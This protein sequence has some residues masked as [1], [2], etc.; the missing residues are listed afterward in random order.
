[1]NDE[2]SA[3]LKLACDA[4]RLAGAHTLKYFQRENLKV[5]FKDDASPVTI[6][7]REAEQLIRKQVETAYPQD[8][9]IGEEF[10]DQSGTSGWRWIIDPIDGTKSFIHGVPLYSV[11]IGVGFNNES[12]IG[13]IHVPALSQTLYAAT[14]KGAWFRLG[15]QP[16]RP[17]R[18]SQTTTL[19][20]GTFLTSSIAGFQ[21]RSSWPA[22][23]RLT[24]AAKVTRTW[25]DAYGYLLVATGKAD[26]M[27]DPEMNIWDAAALLPIMQEAGGTYTDWR[28]RPAIDSGD[29]I[30]TNGLLLDEVL[31]LLNG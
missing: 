19:S 28:G 2:L 4:A 20:Q 21:K 1:M 25:G 5:D 6:A 14:G 10:G 17:A 22:F 23:E 13:V 31:S 12:R 8:A 29:G 15:N 16:E 27:V 18:V 30:G 24:K 26:V 7:D 3:R 11:L 9:I